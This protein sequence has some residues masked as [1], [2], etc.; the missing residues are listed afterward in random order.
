MIIYVCII[1][2]FH[3]TEYIITHFSLYFSI[4]DMVVDFSID[5]FGYQLISI[6]KFQKGRSITILF[7]D[8]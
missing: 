8:D 3:N 2:I 1:C 6:L 5:N 7:K 4:V